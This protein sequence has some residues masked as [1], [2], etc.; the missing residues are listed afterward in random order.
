[1][2]SVSS[3]STTTKST[4]S[5]SSAS[6]FSLPLSLAPDKHSSSSSRH[7]H[8]PKISSHSASPPRTDKSG[9]GKSSGTVVSTA[10]DDLKNVK[11]SDRNNAAR[12]AFFSSLTTPPTSPSEEKRITSPKSSA[13][14]DYTVR[15]SPIRTSSSG[16]THYAV[17][18]S[19]PV[20]STQPSS[21][22]KP[23]SL[24]VSSKKTY[25]TGYKSSTP[26]PNSPN[27]PRAFV[28]G[29]VHSNIPRFSGAKPSSS[30]E[31]SDKSKH[32]S[33]NVNKPS[34][35]KSGDTKSKMENV[36][37]SSGTTSE[38]GG[39]GK[40][41][42]CQDIQGEGHASRGEGHKDTAPLISCELK[43]ASAFEAPKTSTP[44]PESVSR[45][46]DQSQKTAP[47]VKPKKVPPP[48]PPRKSSKHP[49]QVVSALIS[50]PADNTGSVSMISPV[51]MEMSQPQHEM[52][53][54]KMLTSQDSSV[55]VGYQIGSSQPGVTMTSTP[56]PE[57]LPKPSTKFEKGL[58]LG[59]ASEKYSEKTKDSGTSEK[60]KLADRKETDI[61]RCDQELKSE[62][63]DSSESCSSLDSQQG[64]VNVIVV[65]R[66][67][68]SSSLEGGVKK[69]KPPPP[70]RHSSLSG[71]PKS[72]VV[73][74]Q[75][76]NGKSVSQSD[77]KS[78]A[79][80]DD[81]KV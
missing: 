5:A 49:S 58:A 10:E 79:Q 34:I 45:S 46:D 68:S 59:L 24:P 65:N 51:K 26:S 27:I 8:K 75:I 37:E 19:V 71:Q 57:L 72:D 1:M 38:H 62:D 80:G 21:T 16:E 39:V 32:S 52:D 64:G 44:K 33:E 35:L 76:P 11:I 2:S 55:L 4:S 18:K 28:K 61:K 7:S 69:P 23:T 20:S 17:A 54:T 60:E 6:K 43:H 15:I 9:D 77:G 81:G 50:A 48:P 29:M 22:T 56:K 78:S 53:S 73:T 42:G 40:G 36:T 66:R 25:N 12:A 63:R 67:S 3:S 41:E 14:M 31:S 74:E 13:K 47:F 30:S 70:K